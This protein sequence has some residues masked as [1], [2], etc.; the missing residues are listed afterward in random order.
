MEREIDHELGF[1]QPEPEFPITSAGRADRLCELGDQAP[2]VAARVA[3][4]LAEEP[5]TAVCQRM[6]LL[7][8]VAR[9]VLAARTARTRVVA[10]RERRRPMSREP[11]DLLTQEH[12]IGTYDSLRVVLVERHASPLKEAQR[13]G[14]VACV[15][16]EA[17]ETDQRQSVRRFVAHCVLVRLACARDI[18]GE[19]ER[20]AL[21]PM[22]ASHAFPR[23][24]RA[25]TRAERH[26]QTRICVSRDMLGHDHL[27]RH[28]RLERRCSE[29]GHQL[30][31]VP[32]VQ[33]PVTARHGQ[34]AQPERKVGR[35]E[36]VVVKVMH[37]REPVSAMPANEGSGVRV[38]PQHR[39]SLELQPRG[40]QQFVNRR[41]DRRQIDVTVRRKCVPQQILDTELRQ[42]IVLAG[43]PV[44]KLFRRCVT[45]E[46]VPDQFHKHAALRRVTRRTR[47]SQVQGRAIDADLDYSPGVLVEPARRADKRVL[48]VV[49]LAIV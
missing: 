16:G 28:R 24:Q 36:L 20:T 30:L 13:S 39:R 9:L 42:V 31:A 15:R 8:E 10:P 6:A 23:L 18:A 43:Q 21:E 48:A 3:D 38:V 35:V 27:R 46:P 14:S 45:I 26:Q 34:Q 29:I 37:A 2:V 12:V 41:Y 40:R 49:G 1:E 7:A 22:H 25:H 19:V 4:G 11:L 17:G 47:R 44:D 33:R 32:L 5:M